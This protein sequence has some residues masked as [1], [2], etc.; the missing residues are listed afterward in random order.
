VE[1]SSLSA[2]PT[3]DARPVVAAVLGTR[4]EA[5]KLVPVV[6]E[7]REHK[8][9]L[10]TVVISTGQHRE[11]LDQVLRPFD[12]SVDHDMALMQPS[13]SLYELSSRSILAFENVLAQFAPRLVLVQGDTTT[14]FIGALAAFYSK[15]PVAHVEAGL[16]TGHKYSP[17]PEE[18]NRRL[19]TVLADMHFAPTAENRQNLLREGIPAEKIFVTG[20]TGVDMLL[21]ARDVGPKSASKLLALDG[22]R[23]ILVTVHRRESFGEGFSEI[24]HALRDLAVAVPDAL[25]FFPVHL[26]PNVRQPAHDILGGTPNIILTE[27]LDYFAFVDAMSQAALILTDSGGIQ[28]EAPTLGVPV[29]V[30]RKQT[31]RPEGLASGNIRLAGVDRRSIVEQ[32]LRILESP[33]VAT[34]NPSANPYGDGKASAR[35]VKEVLRFLELPDHGKYDGVGEFR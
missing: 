28:E 23:L 3:G 10:R 4:P 27:P 33:S 17:F 26:N 18:I 25:I 5:V 14:A 29:L 16:R 11:M 6:R 9:A 24:F 13:Q 2:H 34:H 8:D 30:L 19:I 15:V 21:A 1:G 35:I 12:I 7:L 20:N 22:K 31:E 32:A